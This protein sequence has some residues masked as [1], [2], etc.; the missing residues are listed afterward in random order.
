[1]KRRIL[2]VLLGLGVI[3]AGSGTALAAGFNIYEAGVRATGLGGAFTATADDGSC[4][5]Y[6][7]AG[8][9]FMD[10]SRLNLDFMLV[11]PRFKFTE[12]A[13]FAAGDP[14]TGEVAHN[15]YFL[16][17]ASYTKNG[18]GCLAYG[19]G[20]YAPF[21]LG[22][23]WMNPDEW[24]GRQVSY[25]ASI[26][27]IYVTPAVS[28]KLGDQLALAVGVDLAVQ[29]LELSKMTLNPDTGANAIDTHIEGT[30]KPNVTPA[31]GLMFRPNDQLSIGA[32]YHWQKT[33]KYEDQDAT[34]TDM[35]DL[36]ATNLLAAVGGS[37]QK[38]SADFNLPSI[39]S[40]G[41]A[42]RFSERLAVEMNMV[43]F[44]WEH[45]DKLDIDFTDSVLLDQTI[46]FDYE[47][48]WQMRLGAD[49]DVMQDK[50]KLMLGYV[51]DH[52]PQPPSS[53]SPLLPDSDRDDYSLGLLLRNGKWDLQAS[54]MAVISAERTNIVD[55]DRANTDLAY[56]VGTYKSVANIFGLGVG[57]HF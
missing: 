51:R 37:D 57:Y 39:F 47:N 20:L 23:E 24:I 3:A 14:A 12:A 43:H 26:Q 44:G 45:F 29:K 27:T 40:V 41:A 46:H 55:G 10:G 56:P 48:R 33:M 16:P 32:M 50:M 1:M 52:T 35:G 42:F 5:F 9:S 28:Y 53:V 25:D 11:A 38:V 31:L 7:P 18:D 4:L 49:V 36:W 13:D 2:T 34:M 15:S 8:L 6:N 19:V 54:Y 30:S 22:V 17:G 21:G